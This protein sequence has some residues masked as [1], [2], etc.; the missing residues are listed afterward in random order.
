MRAKKKNKKFFFNFIQF[1]SVINCDYAP[2]GLRVP[3]NSLLFLFYFYGRLVYSLITCIWCEIWFYLLKSL[4]I[5]DWRVVTERWNIYPLYFFFQVH[6]SHALQRARFVNFWACFTFKRKSPPEPISTSTVSA[7]DQEI[8]VNC[9]CTQCEWRIGNWWGCHLKVTTRF[10][11]SQYGAFLF[12]HLFN[13]FF[14]STIKNE[15]MSAVCVNRN[16]INVIAIHFHLS[17]GVTSKP[18]TSAHYTFDKCFRTRLTF[19]VSFVLFVFGF[20]CVA[21]TRH[22]HIWNS[23]SG[24]TARLRTT[25]PHECVYVLCTS[26]YFARAVSSLRPQAK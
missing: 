14:F 23:K 16:H 9:I 3:R 7:W 4:R 13:Y 11:L 26:T 10:G 15:M 6:T 22:R 21:T 19:R 25:S 5:Y 24:P 18:I 17:P 20:A 12:I 2:D 8:D 1:K